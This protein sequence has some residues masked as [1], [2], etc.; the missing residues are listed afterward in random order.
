MSV[1]VHFRGLHPFIAE[2]FRDFVMSHPDIYNS[3]V[4]H[5]DALSLSPPDPRS[6]AGSGGKQERRGAA[7]E[8]QHHDASIEPPPRLRG[9]GRGGVC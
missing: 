7:A 2:Y 8:P 5:P 6:H 1:N 3:Q 4:G 9:G